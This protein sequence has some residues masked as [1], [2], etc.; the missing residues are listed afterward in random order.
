MIKL[1]FIQNKRNG[2]KFFDSDNQARPHFVAGFTLV[3]ILIVLGMI[4]LLL[5]LTLISL[6]GVIERWNLRIAKD[7]VVQTLKHAQFLSLTLRTSH[8]ILGS[9]TR[10][11][12]QKQGQPPIEPSWESL[13]DNLSLTANRWPSFSAFGFATAGT[14]SL[15]SEH[16]S[17]QIKVSS[18]GS[19]RHTEI[20]AK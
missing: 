16:Y 8:Q 1:I 2:Y 5:T 12:I 15:Q 18:I 17:L 14:I 9:G 10:L 4:S 19:I 3:E 6:E 20:Q 7:Q 11:W 13:S